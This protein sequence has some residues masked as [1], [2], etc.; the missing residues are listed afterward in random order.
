LLLGVLIALPAMALYERFEYTY[1]GQTLI[2]MVIDEEAKLCATSQGSITN[3]YNAVIRPGNVISDGVTLPAHPMWGDTEYTLTQI[4]KFSFGTDRQI[5]V[6]VR[7][8]KYDYKDWQDDIYEVVIPNTVTTVGQQV[9]CGSKIIN[10]DF[11]SVESICGIDYYSE[12]EL[13]ISNAENV[14]INGEEVTDL[15]IPESV[16]HICDYAFSGWGSL[17][18]VTIP[19]SV[20]SIGWGAFAGCRFEKVEFA[21]IEQLCNIKFY[22][23]DA[24]PLSNAQHVYINGE[25]VTDLVIPESVTSIGNYA[26]YNCSSLTSVVIPGSVKTI[27][28]SAFR[29]CTGITSI[30]IPGSVTYIGG[31]AFENCSSLT[32]LIIADSETPITLIGAFE[33]TPIETLY[34]GRDWFSELSGS[35]KSVTIG[36]QVK[37]IPERAFIFCGNLNSVVIGNSV[38]TIGSYAFGYCSGLTSVVIPNSVTS[39]DTDAFYGCSGLIKSAYPNTIE[40]PF[41]GN[42]LYIAYPADG[43]RIEDGFVYGPDKSAIYFAPL[44]LE[45]EFTIPNSVETIG[46]NAFNRCSSLTSVVIPNSVTS[47]GE[48]AFRYCS[49]LTS[50][51]IPNSLTSISSFAFDGCSGMTS[52]EIPNSVQTIGTYAFYGCSGLTSVVIPNSVKTIDWWVFG[53]CSSL[54]SVVIGNSVETIGYWVFHNCN[55]LKKTAYPNTIENP[56]S[57]GTCISYPADGAIIEDGWV[58][59]PDKSAIYFAPLSLEGEFTIPNSV[60]TIGSEAFSGCS[61][62]TSLT[63]ADGETALAFEKD[64]LKDAPIETLYMGRDWSYAES[65]AI[66]T[67]L[68]SVT[69]GNQVKTIP[70]YA[71]S[72][73]SGLTSV[74]IG[75]SVET[76]NSSAFNGCS[77]LTSVEIGNDVTTMG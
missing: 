48:S 52:V 31:G 13:L 35:L 25:E 39:I 51:I 49:G 77:S 57:N 69:I 10:L 2:Y 42:G 8:G 71:F 70:N 62:L 30:E 53:G 46:D 11:A 23:V 65:A 7:D 14:T 22:S 37:S 76:I 26:F 66:S 20:Q 38:E 3:G 29:N 55:G 74:E 32:S 21:S 6:Y 17:T 33:N 64:A 68:K 28:A 27:G 61:S 18:S 73:C 58:Y 67:G 36:N 60:E 43:A 72:D 4:S 24:N 45:G 63:V 59:G 54:T 56:F 44:S 50:V 1:K 47:L 16:T 5:E 15:V 75:N 19:A 41:K 40:N 34:I 12:D 9:F